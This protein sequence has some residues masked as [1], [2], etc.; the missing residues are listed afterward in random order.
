VKDFVLLSLPVLNSSVEISET[1]VEFVN[2]G[3]FLLPFP[4]QLELTLPNLREPLDC[5]SS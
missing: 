4:T 2:R 3:F 5:I 1:A